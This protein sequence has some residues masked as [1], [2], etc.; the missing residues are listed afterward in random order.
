MDPLKELPLGFGIALAQNE[1]AM[2]RFS[3]LT[4]AQK[5]QLVERTHT[6]SSK[7]EMHA[8]VEHIADGPQPL[9]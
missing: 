6:V 8:L 3:A 9:L 2:R 1:E 5:R 7:A 4:D